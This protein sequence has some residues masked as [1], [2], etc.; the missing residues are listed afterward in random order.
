[1]TKVNFPR[2]FM[3][4]NGES[5]SYITSIGTKKRRGFQ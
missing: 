4:D 2:I 5:G 3:G 1:M